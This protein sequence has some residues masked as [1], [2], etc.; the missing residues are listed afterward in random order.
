MLVVATISYSSPPLRIRSFGFNLFDVANS[1]TSF[2]DGIDVI[3]NFFLLWLDI[4]FNVVESP[5]LESMLEEKYFLFFK[6]NES[7]HFGLNTAFFA[8][9]PNFFD[10]F[11]FF[12]SIERPAP[13]HPNDPD[14][15]IKSFVFAPL[16][17][18]IFFVVPK[19]EKVITS[20]FPSF[21]SPPSI[22]SWH[23]FVA[24]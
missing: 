6:P 3:T 10:D 14:A 16:L 21:V 1:R 23:S 9:V 5:S 17:F 15:I 2:S 4:S 24:F 22:F 7:L 8:F 19:S 13:V 11:F 12:S 20:S 18:T